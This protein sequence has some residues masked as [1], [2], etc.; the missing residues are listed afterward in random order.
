L[1][2]VFVAAL[3]AVVLSGPTIAL[4]ATPAQA[5]ESYVTKAEFRKVKRGMPVKRVHRIFDVDGKQTMYFPAYPS[6]GIPAEQSREYRVRSKWG[7]VSVDF[8]RKDGRWV[9][10]RKHAYWG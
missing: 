4:T 7:Y 3:T 6:L 8:K 9:M 2:R 5:A 10:A 1:S